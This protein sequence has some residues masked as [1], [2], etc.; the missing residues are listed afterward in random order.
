MTYTNDFV[1]HNIEYLIN[2][3]CANWTVYWTLCIVSVLVIMD[4]VFRGYRTPP[5]R[6]ASGPSLSPFR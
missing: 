4:G 3:Q 1:W 5:K 6:S 2:N